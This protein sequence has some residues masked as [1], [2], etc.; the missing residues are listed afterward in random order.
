MTNEEKIDILLKMKKILL[1][2]KSRSYHSII[3]N[4]HSYICNAF[5][6]ATKLPASKTFKTIPELLKYKPKKLYHDDVWFSV[7]EEGTRL[8]VEVIENTINDLKET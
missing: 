5:T 1:D 7:D 3:L 6:F 8:R 2:V 4:G